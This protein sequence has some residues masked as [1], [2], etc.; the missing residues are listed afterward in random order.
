MGFNNGGVLE[1]SAIEIRKFKCDY[2][3]GIIGKN[4]ATAN[5]NAVDD[6][7]VSVWKALT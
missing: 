5:E 6:Y 4:K 2:R 7:L 1:L 3:V